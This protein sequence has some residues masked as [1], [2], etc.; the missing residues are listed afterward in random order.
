MPEKLVILIPARGNSKRIPLK[1]LALLNGKP[2]LQYSIEAALKVTTQVYVSTEN[3]KIFNFAKEHGAI[4]ISRPMYLTSDETTQEEVIR[5]FLGRVDFGHIILLECTSPLITA[6]DLQAMVNNY[7]GDFP[8]I[9][10]AKHTLFRVDILANQLAKVPERK[11][12]QDFGL[13]DYTYTEAGA[14]LFSLKHF[15][16][17]SSRTAEFNNFVIMEGPNVDID[18]ELDLKIAEV[19][20]RNS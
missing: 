11:R 16:S 15:L 7:D 19:V 12:S 6:N 3:A 4:P 9:L 5:D 18:T 2:L 20:L 1:N 10:L 17:H 14:W 8:I 13:K